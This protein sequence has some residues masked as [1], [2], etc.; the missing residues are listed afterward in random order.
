[1]RRFIIHIAAL[2]L[3]LA[4]PYAAAGQTCSSQPPTPEAVRKGLALALKTHNRLEQSEA[5]VVLIGRVGSDLSEH[6]LRY[7]HAGYA[8]RDDP[9]SRWLVTHLLNRCGSAD[10]ALLNEGLGNFFLDDPFAYEAVVIVPSPAWQ[11]KLTAMLASQLPADLH[12]R[13]Y[14]MIAHP[15]S[16]RYQNSNQWLLELIAAS[17]AAKGAVV[18]HADAHRWLR[19]AGYTPSQVKIS[20]LQRLGARLFSA[21]VRFD[22]HD[23]R[24]TENG[25]YQIVSVE[26]VINLVVRLDRHARQV[27]VTLDR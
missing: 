23:V 12:T 24:E 25:R 13:N 10:S 6:G 9:E 18:S 7:S 21:N 20:P 22:D 17:M 14:N 19:E 2:V 1:M 8:W 26:S 5:K 11:Q 3:L 16:T 4:A 15:Y 27:V